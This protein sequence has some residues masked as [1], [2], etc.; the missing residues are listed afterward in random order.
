MYW[1][2]YCDEAIAH[3][4]KTDLALGGPK[5][6]AWMQEHALEC[7]DCL[8]AAKFKDL[9]FRVAKRMGGRAVMAFHLG[10]SDLLTMPGYMENLKTVFDEKIASGDLT[11][12]DAEWTAAMAIRH[13]T[14]WPGHES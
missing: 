5:R 11:Q 1:C 13:G 7:Q 10:S 6:V 2:G 4:E 8:R 3:T 12:E 14:P 9:E